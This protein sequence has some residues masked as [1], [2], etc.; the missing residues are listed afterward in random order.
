MKKVVVIFSDF[1]FRAIIAFIR[2]LEK[3]NIQYGIIAKSSEDKIFR[4]SYGSKVVYIRKTVLLDLDDIIMGLNQL[5]IKLEYDECMI[6][7]STE[8]LNRFYLDNKSLFSKVNCFMP[9][10]QKNLYEKISDKLSFCEL[11]KKYNIDV[12]KEYYS[13]DEINLPIVAKPKKYYSSEKEINIPQILKTKNDLLEFKKKYKLSDFYYQEYVGGRCIYLLYYFDKTGKIFKLSQENLIQQEQGKSMI[14]AV[15]SDFHQYEISNKFEHLFI[16]ESFRGLV[17][18]ELK[19]DKNKLIMIEANPRFWGPSQLFVDA[20]YNFFNCLLFDYGYINEEE[21]IHNIKKSTHYFWNDGIFNNIDT[22]EDI[23]FYN[24]SR[25]NF[26]EEKESLI[27][28]EIFNRKDT[29]N[30]FKDAL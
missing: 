24:Y 22:R 29:I 4:T 9:V 11:C 25:D 10:V 13:L 17:M 12:P 15:L 1:N 27:K 26:I 23:T 8:A 3:A 20:N 19:V 30:I 16:K 21:S 5:K 7:P 14:Y 18:I 6:A 28:F 2:T